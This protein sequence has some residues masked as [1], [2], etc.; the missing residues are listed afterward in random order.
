MF[1]DRARV[2]IEGSADEDAEATCQMLEWAVGEMRRSY[3]V[4]TAKNLTLT[5]E[6]SRRKGSGFH[7]IY[8]IVDECQILY[9]APHP[10]GGTKDDA[11][12]WRAAKRLHDQARAVN[13]HLIQA[14]QRPD[15]RTLPV[16]VREGAHVRAALNVPNAET[17]KMILADAADRGARPQD[18]RPGR[19]AGT[20]VA[21]GEVEDIPAGQAFTIVRTHFVNGME[22][23]EVVRRSVELRRKHGA[24]DSPEPLLEH[25]ELLADVVEVMAGANRMKS[26]DVL[27]QLKQNLPDAYGA[28]GA[29]DLAAALRAE[30]VEI[31]QGRL[32]G[33][34][35]QRYVSADDVQ[36]AMEHPATPDG[37]S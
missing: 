36:H 5:R 3:E 1:A 4:K 12:A 26:A 33:E 19:D 29:Q 8:V 32:N 21:T 34:A 11:R 18:L 14:T 6:L 31:R 24:A 28:W 16:Q 27:Q 35:G 22:A 37:D 13:I 2:L 23:A 30:K 20:V 7:P 10:V 15:N 9:A 25:R 17:T